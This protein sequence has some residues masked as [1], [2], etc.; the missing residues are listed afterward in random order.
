MKFNFQYVKRNWIMFAVIV[1]VFGV[2]FWFIVNRGSGGGSAGGTSYVSTGPS[3]MELAAQTQLAGM[4]IQAAAQVQQGQLQL[5]A[6]QAQSQGELA[7]ANLQG[8][9]ALAALASQ[10]RTDSTAMEMSLAALEKQLDAQLSITEANNNF[11]IGYASL[12]YD[13]ATEQAQLNAQLTRDLSAQQLA[14]YQQSALLSV[15]PSLKK[16][17]RDNAL[18]GIAG[19]QYRGVNY[20][21]PT[22]QP[23]ALPPPSAPPIS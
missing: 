11:Q 10:E 2:I 21:P 15:L 3:E 9:V 14:A 8:Q 7:L 22:S 6:I 1:V 13:A 17:D 5:A 12:A 4:Q 18:A 23:L 16:K 19:I 20:A